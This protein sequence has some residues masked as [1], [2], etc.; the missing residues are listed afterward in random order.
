MQVVGEEGVAPGPG[1][2]ELRSR[3]APTALPRF[4]LFQK[5]FRPFFLLASLHGVVVT[6]VWVL[7]L[8][9]VVLPGGHGGP[10][11]WHAHEMLFGF[12]CAVVAG[13]LLTAVGNWTGR[14][15]A[16]GP[17]LAA[18]ATLWLLARIVA[19]FERYLP[20][21][22]LAVDLAFL[23]ALG[24]VLARP[25]LAAK[26]RRNF[27][28]LAV[29]AALWAA[30]LWTHVGGGLRG[31]ERQGVLLAVDVVVVLLVI[32]S[33]RVV[34]MFTR[35]ATRDEGVRS[36]PVLDTLAVVAVVMLAL[37]NGIGVSP[38]KARLVAAIASALLVVRSRHWGAL[39]TVEVPL[40]WILHVGHAF[41]PVG[42]ALRAVGGGVPS[43]VGTHALTVGAIGCLTLGMMARVALGHTGRLLE[44]SGSVVL[45]FAL[46]VGAALLRVVGVL[47]FPAHHASWVAAAGVSWA[48]A[49]GLYFAAY[50]PVCVS[51]RVDGRAG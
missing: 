12:S 42:L 23:P 28:M 26:S 41:I 36:Y 18:L 24:I 37:A 17:L 20:P 27:V 25:L 34:P 33:G 15:T 22:A 16:T 31:G 45:A 50:L 19:A 32:I 5:G 13:F 38:A 14:E 2:V 30:D 49:F 3:P 11:L 9:G 44:P 51:P 7:A 46:V 39:R 10:Q 43:S 35:N 40:L 21:F 29:L 6:L 48:V 8:R 4:A 47:A 1:L